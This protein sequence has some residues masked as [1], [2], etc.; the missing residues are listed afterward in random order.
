MSH[1]CAE[2]RLYRPVIVNPQSVVNSAELTLKIN[3]PT[4]PLINRE[5]RLILAAVENNTLQLG[6]SCRSDKP[7]T[8]SFRLCQ[9][10]SSFSPRR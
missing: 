10:P 9:F 5:A 3:D 6:W 1:C 8:P 4:T 2:C 7:T